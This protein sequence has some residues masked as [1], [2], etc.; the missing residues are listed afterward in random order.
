MK[1]LLLNYEYFPLGGGGS[2]VTKYIGENLAKMGCEVHLITS[3]Y[4]GLKREEN[5]NGIHVNRVRVKRKRRDHCTVFE[6]FTYIVSGTLEAIRFVRKE[7]PDVM[8]AFFVV[9]SGAVAYAVNKIFKVPYLVYLGGSDVPGIDKDRY[10][11]FYDMV[12]PFVRWI[13]GKAYITTAAS[14]GLITYAHKADPSVDIKMVPNGV[15]IDR[16]RPVKRSHKRVRI[17]AIGR[18]IPRKGFQYII[19]A[20]PE[21]VKKTRNIFHL[22]IIGSGPYKEQLEKLAESLGVSEYVTFMGLVEYDQLHREY[23]K[24]DILVNSSYGEGMPCVVLEAMGCGLPIV[25]SD[26]PGNE[27][28]VRTGVN[29]SLVKPRNPAAIARALTALVN[30]KDKRERMG[31]KSREMV[32]QYAWTNIASVY[33]QIYN[34]AAHDGLSG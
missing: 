14:H 32:K 30:S 29:G 5:I 4:K 17:L 24:A 21:V 11:A 19:R 10:G 18:L 12:T 25:A 1:V 27:E 7:R 9:P 34:G 2:T 8:H 16:F 22:D 23:Q 28:L 20:L 6:M 33:K 13:W 15:D 26:I 31:G 3:H